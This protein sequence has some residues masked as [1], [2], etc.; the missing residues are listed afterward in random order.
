VLHKKSSFE[1]TALNEKVAELTTQ[2]LGAEAAKQELKA[3]Q[4]ETTKSLSACS[5]RSKQ[6][7]I[8]AFCY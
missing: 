7:G 4:E 6:F 5:K 1:K 2:L 8:A 3:K